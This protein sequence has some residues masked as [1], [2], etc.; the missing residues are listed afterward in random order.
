MNKKGLI[1]LSGG[2]DSLVSLDLARKHCEVVLSLTFDY[3]QK[4]FVEEKKSAKKISEKYNIKNEII[5]LDFLKNILD[6]ALVSK[7]NC[8]FD[9]FSQ[10]WIPNRNG[11][12]LNIA[13][14]YCDKFDIDYIIFGANKEEAGKF[15]DN[16][17]EFINASNIFFNHSTQKHP[18]VLAPCQDFDKIQ[19][20]DYAI[21]N[22]VP[23]NL[24]KSCYNSFKNTNKKHCGVCMSCKY[25]KEAI[26]K[27][28]NPD[29]V[30]ELF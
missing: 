21:E 27:S 16:S 29:L 23:I 1:L 26:L 7:D 13:G 11:L 15:S 17:L 30:K 18:K 5:K 22:Q 25:L 14:V 3:G 4:A 12:F 28:K 20:I 8:S 24:I 9:D 19:I 6:N 10:V 2:L